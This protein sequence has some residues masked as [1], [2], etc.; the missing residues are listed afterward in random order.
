MIPRSEFPH[1]PYTDHST[2]ERQMR[3]LQAAWMREQVLVAFRALR[4]RIGIS[5]GVP[6]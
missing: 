5:G 3:A 4:A 2:L 6:A 1:L